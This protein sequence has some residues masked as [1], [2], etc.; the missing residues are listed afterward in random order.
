[1]PMCP[2]NTRVL[3]CTSR[4]VGCPKCNVRVTSVVPS[5][6]IVGQ[7]DGSKENLAQRGESHVLTTRVTEVHFL[8]RNLFCRL[9][10]WL[11]MN[12]GAIAS[13]ARDGIK[14]EPLEERL[15]PLMFIST[16]PAG[17][18]RRVNDRKASSLSAPSTSFNV[19]P[20]ANWSSNQAK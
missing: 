17:R 14:T 10:V 5:L 13:T 15:L 20:L 8:G 11:V 4:A 1:M 2:F 19:A 16:W 12:D 9:G 3:Q 7:P 6:S 18:A